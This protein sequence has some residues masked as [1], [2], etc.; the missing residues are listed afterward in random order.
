[1][2][3]YVLI[4]IPILAVTA[5]YFLFFSPKGSKPPE[6][7][8]L[9]ITHVSDQDES[10]KLGTKK[11]GGYCY[12]ATTTM[13][14]KHLDPKIEFWQVLAAQGTTN[15]FSYLS[16]NNGAKVK[17][18]LNERTDAL[19]NAIANMGYHAHLRFYDIPFNNSYSFWRQTA[20][21]TNAEVKTYWFTPP[22][23]E[24]K[25]IIASG[26]PLGAMGS[27]CHNDY[28]VIEGYS[29]NQWFAVIPNPNDVGKTNPKT[30]CSLGN[31]DFV[32]WATADSQKINH[33][34]I[35]KEMKINGME[36]LVN[37]VSYTEHLEQGSVISS[38]EFEKIYLSREVAAKYLGSLGLTDLAN[39][40]KQSA[41]LLFE[42]SQIYPHDVN[43]QKDK[44][45][46]TFKLVENNERN[47]IEAWNKVDPSNF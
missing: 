47:L 42:V 39:G 13:L 17:A 1:M 33:R 2:K 12:L 28:N 36:S 25:N 24:Y 45:I 18:G 3:K 31:L 44:V 15:S 23:N 26:M 5:I 38:P 9:N 30:S 22:T 29:K 43:K 4:F 11:V 20:K 14:L 37:M 27:P 46:S 6:E 35:L 10:Q 34:T 16:E 8:K 21:E 32:F 41:G 19:L 40:Y 7:Y